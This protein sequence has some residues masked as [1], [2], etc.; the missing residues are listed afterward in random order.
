[1]EQLDIITIVCIGLALLSAALIIW[2][3]IK[4][5]DAFEF[6]EDPIPCDDMPA[7]YEDYEQVFCNP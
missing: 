7:Q 1:M 2:I 4:G 5:T 6:D 3:F